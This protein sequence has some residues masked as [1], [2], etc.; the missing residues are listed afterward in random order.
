M[1]QARLLAQRARLGSR[2]LAIAS[3]EQKNRALSALTELL[4]A[5][6]VELQAANREDLEA[7][8]VAG[9]APAM[10][11]RLELTEKRL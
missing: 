7:A 10:L 1:N 2:A 3:T 9:L 6:F 4:S 5:R 8:H 11:D